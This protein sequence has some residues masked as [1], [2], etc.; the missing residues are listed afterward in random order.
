MLSVVIDRAESTLFGVSEDRT[1]RDLVSVKQIA[2][3]YLERV[4]K[5][6][7]QGEDIIGV[8]TGFT[9]LDRLLGGLE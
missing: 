6:H 8:P 7:Q 2:R 3:E 1:T 4:E 5:L 9:D